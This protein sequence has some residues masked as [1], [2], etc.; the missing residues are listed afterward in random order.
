MNGIEILKLLG[1]STENVGNTYV[2]V[3]FDDEMML[4]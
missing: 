1:K 2:T 3:A 4:Q